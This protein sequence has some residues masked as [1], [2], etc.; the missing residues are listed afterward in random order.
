MRGHYLSVGALFD[1]DA[2]LKHVFALGP[3]FVM[4]RLSGGVA[5]REYLNLELPAVLKRRVDMLARLVDDSVLHVEFQCRNDPRMGKRMAVYHALLAE[6][7]DEVRSVVIYFGRGAMRMPRGMST[8]QMQFGFPLIDIREFD[9]EELLGTGRA[10]DCELAW[11]A[12]KAALEFERIVQRVAGLPDRKRAQVLDLL[13][14]LSDLRK[15]PRSVKL[16]LKSM[17]TRI[18]LREDGLPM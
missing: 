17:D 12:A 7:Y 6:R 1:I 3:T 10:A 13:L 16:E 18:K 5:V 14:V 15:L 8:G 4:E 2:A 11:L 9:V